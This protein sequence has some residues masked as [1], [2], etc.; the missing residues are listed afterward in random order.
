[1]KILVTG[2]CGPMGTILSGCFSALGFDV[3]GIDSAKR[4]ACSGSESDAL[5]DRKLALA[6]LPRF[7]D[8]ELDTG[9]RRGVIDLIGAV[10]PDAV[11]HA[12]SQ[13]D[14]LAAPD[15]A[16]HADAATE[17]GLPGYV[18]A[19]AASTLN[20]LE[21]TRRACAS[22]PFVF[23][24]TKSIYGE[25][26]NRI[27]LRELET[28][29]E[30][31][32]ERYA[33]GIPE[34]FPIDD[35]KASA[36]SHC[37]VAADVMVQEYGHYFG[38]PTVCLRV[39]S[40]VGAHLV[41]ERYGEHSRIPAGG[42]LAD[43]VRWNVEERA[44][45][46]A[47]GTDRYVRDYIHAFDVARFVH[48]FVRSPRVGAVYN[49]G[50]GRA[51]ACSILEAVELIED[52]TGKKQRILPA[53][54]YVAGDHTCYYSDIRRAKAHYPGWDVTVGLREIIEG[55]AAEPLFRQAA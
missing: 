13:S 15:A 33:H 31:A 5:R 21:A 7:V 28:R 54:E 10:R 2:S 19:S 32:D 48:E 25:G 29:W 38:L 34:T 36:V 24:S 42:F 3:H 18:D 6:R 1:M 52:V 39:G 22:T 37:K 46:V 17:A 30:F 16:H 41:A 35:C 43:L 51:N 53:D 8:H 27:A 55:V 4:T 9:D 11:V 14:I 50:G 23:L 47:A 49:I 40:V 20:L 12:A 44:F 26:P 45:P